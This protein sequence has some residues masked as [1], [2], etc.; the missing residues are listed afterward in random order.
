M[1]DAEPDRGQTLTSSP[2]EVERFNDAQV[3]LDEA[4]P[5]LAEHEAEHNLLFGIASTLVVDPDRFAP[6]TRRTWPWPDA[7]ARSSPRRS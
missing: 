6:A 5:Y 2:I 7:T 4:G 1:S 3:F